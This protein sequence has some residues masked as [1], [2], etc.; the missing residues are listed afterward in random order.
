MRIGKKI[1][2]D[3][4]HMLS[5]Y[6]GKCA[7][8]HGHTYHGYV[9]IEGEIEEAMRMVLD[10]NCIKEVVD[11]YDHALI[12]SAPKR[13]NSAEQALCEWALEHKMRMYIMNERHPKT[14]A[15]DMA[16]DIAENILRFRIQ[17]EWKVSVSL[18]ETDGSYAEVTVCSRENND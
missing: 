15:E 4:A 1:K 18:S 6:T 2:F 3:C 10:Y 7:N 13:R 9:L 8:L 12:L 5:N 14:T 16:Y 11:M 17:G